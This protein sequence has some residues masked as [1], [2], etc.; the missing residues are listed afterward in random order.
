M[1]LLKATVYISC[2]LLAGLPISSGSGEFPVLEVCLA[3]DR[4]ELINTYNTT[5]W[6]LHPSPVSSPRPSQLPPSL[7]LGTAGPA[8]LLTLLGMQ[9]SLTS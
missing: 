1:Y 3:M 9:G 6:A 4:P 8:P 7:H 2:C 5:V